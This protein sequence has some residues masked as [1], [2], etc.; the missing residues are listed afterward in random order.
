M[1]GTYKCSVNI[2]CY[3]SVC[4]SQTFSMLYIVKKKKKCFTVT[5]CNIE[6]AKREVYIV[7]KLS[8]VP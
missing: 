7:L 4:C 1:F 3:F 2:S 8:I 5:G 6:G